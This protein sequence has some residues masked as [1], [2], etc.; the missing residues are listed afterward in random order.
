MNI[1]HALPAT[2]RTRTPTKHA[3]DNEP[4]AE[5][6]WSLIAWTM[7]AGSDV[8]APRVTLEM[9]SPGG[10]ARFAVHEG[11]CQFDSLIECARIITGKALNVRSWEARTDWCKAGAWTDGILTVERNGAVVRTSGCATNALAA[12]VQ[13]LLRAIVAE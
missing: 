8:C 1:S 13:A 12:F 7:D 10:G 5:N 2:A 3:P 6:A 11:P 9:R 4:S